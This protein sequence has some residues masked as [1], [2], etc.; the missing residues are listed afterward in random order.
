MKHSIIAILVI[1]LSVSAEA[2]EVDTVMLRQALS[3][4]DTIVY[5]RIVRFDDRDSLYHVQDF[6]P[7]GQIQM[8]AAYSSLDRTIKEE[9]QCDYRTNRKQG[10][11][12]EWYD[13]G[14]IE[15]SATF[16]NGKRNGVSHEWYRNGQL[17]EEENWL[18]GQ[19]DGTVKYW[20]EDGKLQFDLQ[21]EQ[22]VCRNTRDTSYQYLSY[23]PPGYDEDT[24]VRWPMIVYLHGGSRRGSDIKKLY[25]D[26]IPDQIYRGREFPFVIVAPQCPEHIRWSTENWFENLYEEVSNKYR[27]DTN[28]VYLT[29]VS[30]GGSGTWYLAIQYPSRFAAIAPMCGFTS[31]TEF[32]GKN[33]ARLANMPIWAF[34][35]QDD[36][37]VPV[38][39]TDRVIE[40]LLGRN[41]DLKVTIE[42]G[43]G[44]GIY[45]SVYPH[46]GL[47]DWFLQYSTSLR[48]RD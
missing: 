18:N 1:V 8:E 4:S 24:S 25:A 9:Y 30:L 39:E 38:E 37:V 42:P 35:G 31:H 21:F 3:K 23:V 46:T 20:S 41:E 27:I 47:Y 45:W 16:R 29:G 10:I 33:V 19:L 15:Y 11:Y 12:K 36:L 44:H 13:N 32:I 40:K 2:Q 43:V 6:L 28:R 14:Q 5:T 48:K 17:A 22:G 34:H 26:G 7:S